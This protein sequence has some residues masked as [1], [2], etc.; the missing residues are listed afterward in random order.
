MISEFQNFVDFNFPTQPLHK[1]GTC[2]P[3]FLGEGLGVGRVLFYKNFC[4]I[5]I[6]VGYNFYKVVTGIGMKAYAG[7][8]FTA[9]FFVHE[10]LTDGIE[11]KH[12][13]FHLT[14]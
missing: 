4:R 3:P 2:A 14:S 1:E 10:G 8:V 12:F 7:L 9:E 13:T 6:I 11:N 5:S